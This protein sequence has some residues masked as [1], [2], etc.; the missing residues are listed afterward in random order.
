LSSMGASSF[1]REVGRFPS[2]WRMSPMDVKRAQLG[3]T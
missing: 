3:L 2:P 1:R